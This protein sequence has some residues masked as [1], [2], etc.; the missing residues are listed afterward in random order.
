MAVRTFSCSKEVAIIVTREPLFGSLNCFRYL[1]SIL[2][3]TFKTK[4][5]TVDLK[6]SLVGFVFVISLFFLLLIIKTVRHQ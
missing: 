5:L 2:V 4:L 6:L 3:Y 1:I